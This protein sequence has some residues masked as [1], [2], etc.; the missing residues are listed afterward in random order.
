M[1]RNAISLLSSPAL[2][3]QFGKAAIEQAKNFDIENIVP[4]YEKLYADVL[5]K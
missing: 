3:K 2:L 1:S 4:Q 5:N